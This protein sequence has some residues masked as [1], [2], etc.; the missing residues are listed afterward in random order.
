M[1]V[2]SP[3]RDMAAA[4]GLIAFVLFLLIPLSNA[5]GP[6]DHRVAG[7]LHGL[8][9]SFTLVVATYTWH[10]YY[11]YAKGIEADRTKLQVRLIMTNLLSLATLTAGNWLYIG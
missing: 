1:R 6:G 4:Q 8:G 3:Y 11:S 2:G 7:V 5:F 10:A 9:A